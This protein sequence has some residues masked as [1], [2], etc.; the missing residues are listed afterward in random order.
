MYFCPGWN[1]V[2]ANEIKSLKTNSF[3]ISATMIEKNAGIQLDC[4]S[5]FKD[6]DEKNW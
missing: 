3:Y 6:F 1:T 4:G 2:L 5:N